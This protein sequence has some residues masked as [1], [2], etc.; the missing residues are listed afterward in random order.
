MK[1]EG[2]RQELVDSFWSAT[3]RKSLFSRC[4]AAQTGE[5]REKRRGKGEREQ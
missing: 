3:S 4:L 1:R 2:K 5:R